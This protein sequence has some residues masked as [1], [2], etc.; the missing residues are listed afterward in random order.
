MGFSLS[1]AR[2]NKNSTITKYR[3]RAINRRSQLV[4]APLT[5]QTKTQ[6]LCVFY[7]AIRSWI[8]V[9]Q[10][11]LVLVALVSFFLHFNSAFFSAFAISIFSW[12]KYCRN[13]CFKNCHATFQSFLKTEKYLFKPSIG[14]KKS[15]YDVTN[16]RI[17]SFL[18][19]KISKNFIYVQQC[20]C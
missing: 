9:F 1:I 3:T 4:S 6:F 16:Q 18:L 20:A 10:P 14:R 17:S 15:K 7:V 11:R 12:S 13:F 8:F 19:N 2:S 5:F